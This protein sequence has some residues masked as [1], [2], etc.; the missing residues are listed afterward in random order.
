MNEERMQSDPLE[1]GPERFSDPIA[2]PAAPDGEVNVVS[3]I[4]SHT[5]PLAGMTVSQARDELSDR[6]NID[7][8]AQPIVDGHAADEHMVLLEGQ[9]LTFLTA[10]GEKGRGTL[11]IAA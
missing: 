4:Y 6:L 10:A 5:Y 3:G 8:E 11:L 1:S 9:V 2:A 7:P